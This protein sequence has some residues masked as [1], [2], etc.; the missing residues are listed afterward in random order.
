MSVVTSEITLPATK[1]QI[2]I[3]RFIA[4]HIETHGYA[5][6]VREVASRFGNVST[7]AIACHYMSLERRGLIQR[8]DGSKSRALTVTPRGHASLSG[9]PPPPPPASETDELRCR[10]EVLEAQVASLQ[11]AAPRDIPRT[12]E[13]TKGSADGR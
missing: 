7:N 2:E 12:T 9:S 3:L 11:L 4:T 8:P 10:V 1:K 6:A 5:P 13:A